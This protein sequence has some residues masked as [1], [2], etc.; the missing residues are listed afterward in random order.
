MWPNS[1]LKS[2]DFWS[3]KMQRAQVKINF[4]GS[5]HA[6]LAVPGSPIL[7]QL[8]RTSDQRCFC[9]FLGRKT[10]ALVSS[11]EHW[12]PESSLSVSVSFESSSKA[13]SFF[14]T[15]MQREKER[16][17]NS[18]GQR[19]RSSTKKARPRAGPVPCQ[20][21]T[22]PDER[23]ARVFAQARAQQQRDARKREVDQSWEPNHG[24]HGI[25]REAAKV[26]QHGPTL[27]HESQDICGGLEK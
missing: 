18:H 19:Q 23:R 15:M 20:A 25:M 9:F 17:V 14:G 5:C 13:T 3:P 1:G 24:N 10:R 21:Q 27:S 4:L 11:K 2:K 7:R 12:I 26:A 22:P 8:Q 6:C 16:D